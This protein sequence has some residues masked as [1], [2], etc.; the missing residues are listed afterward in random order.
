M[1][2]VVKSLIIQESETPILAL[3]LQKPLPQRDEIYLYS[4]ND[5]DFL[6]ILCNY[7]AMI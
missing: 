4:V 3:N 5:L 7:H 1:L 6:K 2:V